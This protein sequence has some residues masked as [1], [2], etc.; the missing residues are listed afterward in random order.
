[1]WWN[2]KEKKKKKEEVCV[3]S[4]ENFSSALYRQTEA[5]CHSFMHHSLLNTTSYYDSKCNFPTTAF[6]NH[7]PKNFRINT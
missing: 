7:P 4:L 5:M 3:S 1:M 6:F 2:L